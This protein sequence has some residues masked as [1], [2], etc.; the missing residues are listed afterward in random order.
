MFKQKLAILKQKRRRAW[1]KRGCFKFARNMSHYNSRIERLQ[2]VLKAFKPVKNSDV[3]SVG[4]DCLLNTKLDKPALKLSQVTVLG[5]HVFFLPL[6]L[7]MRELY[8]DIF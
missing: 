5:V 3:R 2:K 8:F 6:N 4:S 7:S 1:Y